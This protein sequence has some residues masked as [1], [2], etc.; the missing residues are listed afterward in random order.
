MPVYLFLFIKSHALIPEKLTYMSKSPP[1]N[2]TESENNNA[3]SVPLSAPK[4]YGVVF[5][6]CLILLCNWHYR[7]SSQTLGLMDSCA[8]QQHL[9]RYAVGTCFH[10]PALNYAQFT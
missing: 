4:F 7:V 2:V 9:C 8:V 5:G 3:G 1:C 6:T 10:R